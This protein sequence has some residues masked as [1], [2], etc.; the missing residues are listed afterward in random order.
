LTARLENPAGRSLFGSG[1]ITGK[2]RQRLGSTNLGPCA[3]CGDSVL[4]PASVFPQG[5]GFLNLI[6]HS[7]CKRLAVQREEEAKER[8]EYRCHAALEKRKYI[9]MEYL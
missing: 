9:E 3:F 2:R 4:A 8:D 5:F 1:C 7:Y 6:C